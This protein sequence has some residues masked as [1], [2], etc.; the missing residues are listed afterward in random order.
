MKPKH[1]FAFILL[2][3]VWSSSFL[4][5]KIAVQELSPLMLV[6]LRVLFG[7]LTGLLA[8]V[9]TKTQLPR[10]RS[11]WFALALLGI[12]SV[13]VP[14]MLISWGEKSIDSAV[15]SIL[16]ATVP[17]F[18]ILLASLFL[19]DDRLSPPR[20]LGLLIGFGGVIILLL[21]DL[22]PGSHNSLLG[23]AAVLLAAVFYAGSTVFARLKTDKVP[24]LVRGI[25]PLVS[26]S[27]VMWTGTFVLESP[28]KLP[29]LPITWLAVIW[30]GV[31]G[32]GLAFILWY[33][34]LQEIGPTRTAM[35]TYTMPLGGVILGLI[36]LK[37]PLS[38]NMVSGGLL[39]ALSVW[40]VNRRGGKGK[41]KV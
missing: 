37:E 19:H 8:I 1:W 30:L 6:S 40:L 5:I 11:V 10:G 12:T 7:A 18:T 32:S 9:L 24:G 21:K 16:N 15:A 26:A 34:L 33:Y 20:L 22:D 2:G 27:L 13:A 35:V 17:L 4:W 14:F 41:A 39:I 25:L 38:W 3:A 36:F 23:Q 31:L 29:A 28:L